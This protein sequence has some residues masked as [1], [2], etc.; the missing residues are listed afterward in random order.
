MRH[1]PTKILRI[2]TPLS[3]LL[4]SVA[5]HAQFLSNDSLFTV[6]NSAYGDRIATPLPVI[7]GNLVKVFIGALGIIFL[8]LTIYAGYLYLT[9]RGDEKKVEQAKETLKTGVIGL[10]II[11]AAYAI[12]AFVINALLVSTSATP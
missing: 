4:W 3:L 12:A 8:L 2:I 5:A 7:I 11:A 10:L 1:L 6:G 9:A